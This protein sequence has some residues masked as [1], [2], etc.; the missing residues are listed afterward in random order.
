M[1]ENIVGL[2]IK[3]QFF[4][5][6]KNMIF[7]PEKTDRISIVYGKNGSGKSTLT[8]GHR[9]VIEESM[10]HELAVSLINR[11]GDI[12]SITE[13]MKQNIHV[14]DEAYVDKNIR[15]EGAGLNTI[16]LFGDQVDVEDE[17]RTLST[18]ITN[19]K[20]NV[21][22]LIAERN[23]Y[24]DI[25]NI[26]S[27]NYHMEKLKKVLKEVGGWA[28]R[29]A[30]IKG[31]KNNSS[32]LDRIITEIGDL[33][34]TNNNLELEIQFK[35]TE[36][37]LYKIS[38]NNVS[39]PNVISKKAEII[40]EEDNIIILLAEKVEKPSLSV[41]EKMILSAIEE[42]FQSR[43]DETKR[44]FEDDTLE[45]C[46]YCYQ[47]LSVE[48]KKQIMDGINNVLNKDVEEHVVKLKK[49]FFEEYD[50]NKT[51]YEVLDATLATEIEKKIEIC[52]ELVRKY[53]EYITHKINNVFSPITISLLGLND[54]IY[55]L[56][57]LLDKLE[58]KRIDFNDLS[59]KA[60][61]IKDKLIDINKQI[62]HNNIAS[63]LCFV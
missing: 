61:K 28:E 23:K 17:I 21:D 7:F 53:N 62:A 48:Y 63:E 25:N 14:F 52:N 54:C 40:K 34:V 3:G 31:N 50:F 22:S 47:P 1:Y 56:N 12:Q 10:H 44:M 39:F 27:P 11:A 18:K 42:G 45:V 4:N 20:S 49:S 35:E 2:S 59:K 9:E 26:L 46:P 6:E 32:V 8:A 5:E 33:K 38:D 57:I 13:D 55:E 19:V 37:L 16:V 36:E 30:R 58:K 51:T 43:V 15:I 29:D 41:R 60:E 24:D